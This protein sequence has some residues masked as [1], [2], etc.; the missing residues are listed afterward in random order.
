MYF[1]IILFIILLVS[2]VPAFFIARKIMDVM[3]A[4]ENKWATL[5]GVLSFMAFFVIFLFIIIAII[6]S[7]VDFGR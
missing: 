3:A 5:A 4:R 2:G 1:P 6:L 7:S